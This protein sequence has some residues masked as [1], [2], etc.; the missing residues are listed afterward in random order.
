MSQDQAPTQAHAPEICPVA[1]VRQDKSQMPNRKSRRTDYVELGSLNYDEGTVKCLAHK[2]S[3]SLL[4]V[5]PDETGFYIDTAIAGNQAYKYWKQTST[6]A[7]PT[8]VKT[9]L[10]KLENEA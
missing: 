8:Y 7:E 3:G 1:S 9:E 4:F 2:R 5:M 6:S 10:E